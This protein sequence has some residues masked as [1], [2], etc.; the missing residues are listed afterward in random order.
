MK[1]RRITKLDPDGTLADNLRR[2][3]DVRLRELESFVPRAL[4]PEAS[5]AQHDMRIAAKR[6]RYVLDLSVPVFGEP[7]AK[8]AKAARRLQ[9][10]LGDL[11][12]CDELLPRARAHVKRLRAEDAAALRAAAGRARDLDPAL[13]REA[14]NR[15]RYRGLESLIAY[16]TAR[17]GLLFERFVRQWDGLERKAF[18]ETLLAGLAQPRPEVSAAERSPAARAGAGAA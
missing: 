13:V 18:G 12:D 2:T 14:P 8:G 11:H 16:L 1:A 4:D 9:E 10:V 15:V 5:K 6:L 3:V 7:A 17:R